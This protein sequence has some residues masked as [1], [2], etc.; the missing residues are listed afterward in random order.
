MIGLNPSTRFLAE[1]IRLQLDRGNNI[2]LHNYY[3]AI[4]NP[5][6]LFNDA[7]YHKVVPCLGLGL[8]YMD[9]TLIDKDL[10]TMVQQRCTTIAERN[11]KSITELVRLLNAFNAQGLE[12]IPYKGPALIAF[13]PG[14]ASRQFYDLD[15]II[16]KCDIPRA[17]Q[18]ITELGYAAKT[19][20]EVIHLNKTLAENNTVDFV[21]AGIDAEVDFHWTMTKSYYQLTI[22]ME[23][24][25]KQS[26]LQSFYGINTRVLSTEDLLI[27]TVIHHGIRNGWKKLMYLSDIAHL[28]QNYPAL[29]WSGLIQSAVSH[30]VQRALLS[31]LAL[32]RNI[33]SISLPD[34]IS[35]LIDSNKAV[36]TIYRQCYRLLSGDLNNI[37]RTYLSL[38]VKVGMREGRVT[39]SKIF[40]R[41]LVIMGAYFTERIYKKKHISHNYS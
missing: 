15:F 35:A 30:K 18:L 40:L 3:N 4:S 24:F 7:R 5:R 36:Q 25:W 32:A 8:N 17:I 27:S 19:P 11:S 39:R 22:D 29:N 28:V 31:G 13:Y 41:E 2:L 34:H 33:F 10:H 23:A 21:H 26:S 9:D 12:A 20:D 14:I 37:Q 16:R 1:C 6:Q 38:M